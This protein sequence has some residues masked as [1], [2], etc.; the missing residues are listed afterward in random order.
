[1]DALNFLKQNKVDLVFLDLE[2]PQISGMESWKTYGKFLPEVIITTSHA[3]FAD[4][5]LSV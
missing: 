2:M 3:D 1:M 5:C 4:K